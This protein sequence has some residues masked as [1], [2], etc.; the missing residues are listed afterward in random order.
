MSA[1]MGGTEILYPL[2]DILA[3]N[4]IPGYPK[5]IFLLTDGGVSDTA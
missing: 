1:D 3:S 5:H 2:R 4:V